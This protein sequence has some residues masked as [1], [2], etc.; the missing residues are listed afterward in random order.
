MVVVFEVDEEVKS[1]SGSVAGRC[2]ARP[3]HRDLGAG[4][5]AGGKG[6]VGDTKV[7]REDDRGEP[8]GRCVQCS[9]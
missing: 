5:R 8:D 6:E 4:C 3:G 1:T 2:R 9:T 7:G